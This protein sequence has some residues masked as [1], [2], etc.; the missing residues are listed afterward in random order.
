MSDIAETISA[1][2]DRHQAGARDEAEVLYRRALDADPR[3]PTALYLYGLFNFEAGRVEAAD[4]LLSQ[5]VAVRPGHAEGHV[6]LANLAYWR[7]RHE[8][9]VDGYKRALAIQPDHAAA[10]INLAS[11]LRDSGQFDAAI[12]ACQNAV[13]RL[14]DPAPAYAAL[15]GTLAAAGR[16]AEATGAFR[17]AIGLAPRD[18]AVRIGLG[19][20]LLDSKEGKAALASAEETLL[21]A[22]DQAEAWFVK[23]SALLALHRPAEAITALER[24]AAIDPDRA[25]TRLGLGNAYAE[26]E[27]AEQAVEQLIRA[28]ELDP[29]SKE[30]HAS[31]G[32]VLYRCGEMELAEKECWLALAADPA[33]AVAHQNLAAIHADRGEAE[34]ARHH[35]DQ[36]YAGRS[37][38]V[39]T[40]PDPKG[41]V[42]VLT[43]T[44]GGNI[45]HRHL[46]PADRYT[47]LNWF[48]EYAEPGQAGELPA[49]D[50]V[51]NIVGDP[52]AAG[53]AEAPITA[54]LKDYP[55]AVINDPAR[56]S[57]TRRDRLSGLFDGLPGLV[58]PKAARLDAATIARTGLAAAIALSGVD[59][60]LLV[61]PIGSHGGTGL[62]L[63]REPSDLAEA[64][65][66]AGVYVT[67]YRDFRSEDGLYR[68]YRVIFA[69]GQAFPYHLAIA[70]DWLVH[71]GTAQMA[72]DALRQA[73]ERRFL[74]DPA[75]ALGAK[76][77]A[78]VTEVGARLGLDYGGID[79]S[80][81]PDGRAVVFEANATMLAHPEDP[82]GEFAY[83]NPYAARIFEAF[84]RM[85]AQRAASGGSP[86]K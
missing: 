84:Q 29:A 6:A 39:E 36:A 37:L 76:A 75:S 2:L 4:R 41:V 64:D 71:Y 67:E 73:E 62:M 32:S 81:L 61:R 47:R 33:M 26:L 83:K 15:G 1:A 79:F 38:V 27:L 22:P 7:G 34:Q 56:V 9:A 42:L 43:T 23:G 46:L 13:G 16:P 44:Q 55:I 18:V 11:A 82:D 74:A 17:T 54:F 31:L 49:Y 72:D 24:S 86:K 30:I 63:A 19:M 3:E 57:A 58:T 21:W 80:V 77:M 65:I 45:P 53:G 51:F 35:R 68:K 14:L 85:I 5:V 28:A 25:A 69:D 50:V 20:A 40:A 70:D 78:A 10:L 60:P 8:A 52:D 12:A 48:I 59:Y 66:R